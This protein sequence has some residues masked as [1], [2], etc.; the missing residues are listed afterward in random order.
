MSALTSFDCFKILTSWTTI[1]YRVKYVLP[2]SFVSSS[3]RYLPTDMCTQRRLESACLSTQ[4]DQSLCYP[5]EE[6]LHLLQSK[7]WPL[8]ILIR[9]HKCAG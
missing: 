1:F 2:F 4:S 6:I 9:F 8:K 3:V 5:H 7:T